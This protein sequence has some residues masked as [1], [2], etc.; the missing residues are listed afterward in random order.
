MKNKFTGL[1]NVFKFAYIQSVKTKTF[2]VTMAI[3]CGIALLALPI[4]TA[5]TRT[6]KEEVDKDNVELI[7]RVY[8]CDQVFDG[9]LAENLVDIIAKSDEYSGKEY[10]IVSKENYDAT[11]DEVKA[12]KKGDILLDISFNENMTDLEYGFSYVVYYGEKV[13]KLDEASDD[14][15]FY[16]DCI[17][18]QALANML[19]NTEEDAKL[20]SYTFTS[21]TI[22]LNLDG[23]S[24]EEDLPGEVV[25]EE[26]ILDMLEYWVTY[27]FL[28][29]SIFSISILGSKVSEQIV[30]EKSSKVIEYIMT[31]IRP[32]A[33]ITGK[34]LASLCILFTMI[35]GVL[36][37]FVGSIFVN[38]MIFKEA[39]GS[40]AL[41][42]FVKS[43]IEQ[44]AFEGLSIIN[45]VSSV[46]VFFLG[47]LMFGFLAG[48]AGATVSKVEEMAEGLKLFTFAMIIGAY[49][50]IA[51]MTS[52]SAG[53]GWGA[54]TN[55]V[56]LFPLCSPFIVPASLLLGK[57]SVGIGLLSVAILLVAIILLMIFVSGVFEY[58]IYYNGSPLKLKELIKIFRKKGGLNDEK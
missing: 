42:G 27:A 51:Y 48:I 21:E 35:A 3:L 33:L 6:E 43:L 7:G 23:E 31:S 30:T 49:V 38:G 25:V 16:I 1:L 19:A 14:F 15:A 56:Y 8:V 17:H 54:F 22:V 2:A 24:T 28:M 12:S 20:L 4:I 26:P 34:V 39:D 18:Q 53:A 57:V 41:P 58:L 36:A 47:F 50:V 40:M 32:M 55:F 13:E 29:I 11:Y 10:V 37:S 52:A 46:F 9:K 44:N 5:I 45:I